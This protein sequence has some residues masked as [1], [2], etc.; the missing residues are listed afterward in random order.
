MRRPMRGEEIAFADAAATSIKPSV[1]ENH[2]DHDGNAPDWARD[3][4][5]GCA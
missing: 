4:I 5:R 1:R 2:D 3:R